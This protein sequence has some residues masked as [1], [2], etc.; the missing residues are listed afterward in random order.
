MINTRACGNILRIQKFHICI[1]KRR[2][3]DSPCKWPM[4]KLAFFRIQFISHIFST[5]ILYLYN[6]QYNLWLS[7]RK[8]VMTNWL[9][10]WPSKMMIEKMRMYKMSRVFLSLILSLR[11]LTSSLWMLEWEKCSPKSWTDI[12]DLNS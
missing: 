2:Y 4:K 5:V 9:T 3:F 11:I 8:V 6:W 12:D 1:L 10:N 7:L